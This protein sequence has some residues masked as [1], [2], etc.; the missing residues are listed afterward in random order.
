[1]CGR[2]THSSWGC[3]TAPISINC[4]STAWAAGP[5]GFELANRAG[6][7][8]SEPTRKP[9][10]PRSTPH[11]LALKAGHR[12][13]AVGGGS[14]RHWRS[15]NPLSQNEQNARRSSII[16]RAGGDWPKFSDGTR[17]LKAAH[18][19][20]ALGQTAT[21]QRENVSP[22]TSCRSFPNWPAAANQLLAQ[23]AWEK[24]PGGSFKTHW[25]WNGGQ[26]ASLQ[27]FPDR[28]LLTV[29]SLRGKICGDTPV[30]TLFAEQIQLFCQASQPVQCRSRR[31]INNAVVG[32][33]NVASTSRQAIGI[34]RANDHRDGVHLFASSL[35]SRAALCSISSA[36]PINTGNVAFPV[37]RSVRSDLRTSS[38]N[39]SSNHRKFDKHTGC[40]PFAGRTAARLAR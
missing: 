2:L 32:S 16:F 14:P 30:G 27:M 3:I 34:W 19:E 1:M 37:I 38:P 35:A 7:Q 13:W 29:E 21:A 15:L 22:A 17:Y 31:Q 11:T 33:L 12:C 23:G 26:P 28:L 5:I 40:S 18:F 20:R 36:R 6:V 10:N 39:T 9:V 4:W 8:I 24:K 25:K